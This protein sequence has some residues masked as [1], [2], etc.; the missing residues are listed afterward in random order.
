[1]NTRVALY[2][3]VS[4]S[5]AKQTVENQL[6]DLNAVADR[7]DWEIVAQFPIGPETRRG[8]LVPGAKVACE[9]LGWRKSAGR[10][11][12]LPRTAQPRAGREVTTFL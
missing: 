8:T 11:H 2:T 6:R 1:M 3:R 10:S 9:T 4:T 7:L 12:Y 5:D